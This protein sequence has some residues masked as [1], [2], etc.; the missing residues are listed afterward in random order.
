MEMAVRLETKNKTTE[1]AIRPFLKW[2]GNKYRVIDQVKSLLP[3]GKRLIEPFAGS[4]ALFLNS[5]YP[6]YLLCDTNADLINLYEI[7]K[8]EGPSFIH[9]C[10]RY[11]NDS[12]NNAE[13]YYAQRDRF[14]ASHNIRQKAAL[15]VY[16]NRHGYN[17][18]CRYNS[19]GGY[20]VPF[21]RYVRPYFP[22]KEMLAFHHKAQSA[23]FKI[24]SFEESF[25]LARKN[26]VIY[27]DPPYVPL[28]LT[29]NFTG[30]SAAGFDLQLQLKLAKLAEQHRDNKG[31]VLIS[32]HDTRFTR[33]AYS[34]ADRLHYFKVRRN[35][36][37]NGKKREHADEVLALF[38]TGRLP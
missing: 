8:Q 25:R 11:F 13:S 16:L 5:D 26:D 1:P 28:T 2:A 9:Y 36:S 35:I 23:D 12:Y 17:G 33:E 24:C 3:E 21:G 20:N 27:A 19:K 7:L 4:A 10:K 38:T 29:A 6:A 30:Y 34:N 18:L 37:C 14:N 32:N 15:F 22:E 31:T